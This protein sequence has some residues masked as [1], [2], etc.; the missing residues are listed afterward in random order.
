MSQAP[1]VAASAEAV[2][3][4]AEPILAAV[5]VWGRGLAPLNGLVKERPLICSKA[6]PALTTTLMGTVTLLVASWNSN[7][8]LKV[9]ATSPPSGR[10]AT[11]IET[12]T[13]EGAVPL[14]GVTLSQTPL[15]NVL[16]ISVQFRVPDPP[17]RT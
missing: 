14:D 6:A 15:L 5:M 2:N 16:E 7:W 4:K 12:E 11:D 10:L 3:V 8:P 1:P 13:N 9:S 17:L